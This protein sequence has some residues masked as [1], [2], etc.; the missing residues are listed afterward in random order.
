MG[1]RARA[2]WREPLLHFLVVGAALWA[3]RE[4]TRPPEADP[5]IIVDPAYVAGLERQHLQRSGRAPADSASLVDEYVREEVLF[6][7]ALRLGL[8]RD[9][10]IVR[11]RLIQKLELLLAAAAEPE[12]PRDAT[13]EAHLAEHAEAFALP[14]RVGFEHVFFAPAR[15]ADAAADATAALAALQDGAD[16]STL[17]DAF[18]LGRRQAAADRE[19]LAG[20][21]GIAFAEAVSAEGPGGWQGPFESRLGLHLVR[22]T[23]RQPGSAP[24]LAE[25][26]AAVE[27]D[28][29]RQVRER[30][31]HE[32]IR[33][34]VERTEVRR[35]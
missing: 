21:Y 35:P 1:A 5:P 14:P 16:P 23:S 13:L 8:E 29:R 25:V 2:F 26:R 27:R 7:E 33:R 15:R 28:W 20:R 32:A 11:R 22:V 6:R 24:A 9:D 18:A 12:D 17:G 19:T 10:P 3:V 31:T 34:L 4:A 30:R